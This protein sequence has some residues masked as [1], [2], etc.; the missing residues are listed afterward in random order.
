VPY[1]ALTDVL[2]GQAPTVHSGEP[3][4]DTYLDMAGDEHPVQFDR[5]VEIGAAEQV[6]SE[7]PAPKPA[8]EKR[9][10]SPPKPAAKD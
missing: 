8:A 1:R 10:R 4:P 5:L 6:Q 7:Q 9:R 2:M 3:I